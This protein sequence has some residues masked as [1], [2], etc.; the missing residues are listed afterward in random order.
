FAVVLT[1][2]VYPLIGHWIWGGGWLADKGFADF[3]GSTVVHSVGGWAALVGAYLLGPRL[4]KYTKSGAVRPIP[5]HS[6]SLVTLGGLILWLGWF[7]FNAGSE[8]AADPHAIARIATVTAIA[9]AVG[10]V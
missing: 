3:A 8:L 4:G 6:M 10:T 1:A 2:V 5:G 9:A 7:G